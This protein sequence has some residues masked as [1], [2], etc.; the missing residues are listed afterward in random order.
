MLP[1][2]TIMDRLRYIVH[3][4]DN[5]NYD[6]KEILDAINNGIRFIRRTIAEIHP[7]ILISTEQGVLAAGEDTIELSVRP[8]KIIRVRTGDELLK[9][10]TTHFS[11]LIYRNSDIIYRNQN[12]IYA[13]KVTDIYREHTLRET[14]FRHV[15][16]DEGSGPVRMFYRTGLKT[17]HFWPQP[18]KLT[19]WTVDKIDDITEVGANDVS[20]LLS[21]FDDFLIEYASLRL[22]VGNEYDET[23]EQQIT[24]NIY[25]QIRD[26]LAPPP[27]G[28]IVDGYWPTAK[29]GGYW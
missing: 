15:P 8:L 18:Q 29:V 24:M 16:D 19:V 17:I 11:P 7:E 10:T 28:V 26:L 14:N 4:T 23:Q 27:P 3:D 22:S 20:P 1:I 21:D 5:V 13:R 6:D 25:S 2:K 9:S 12:L